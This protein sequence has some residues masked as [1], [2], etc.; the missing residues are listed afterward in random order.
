MTK[1]NSV[2]GFD[3]IRKGFRTDPAAYIKRGPLVLAKAKR[4]GDAREQIFPDASV[5]GK[6]YSVSLKPVQ[7]DGVW[8]AWVKM[9]TGKDNGAVESQS[10]ASEGDVRLVGGLQICWGN[11]ASG[12]YKSFPKAFS[13]KPAVVTGHSMSG[14][15]GNTVAT[16]AYIETSR[17]YYKSTGSS[18]GRYVA[19]GPWA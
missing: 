9:L 7:A 15:D 19:F 14:T 16:G 2:P 13:A 3:D 18:G 1:P 8:G 12:S 11:C 17:F 4:I 10:I 5:N 6:G